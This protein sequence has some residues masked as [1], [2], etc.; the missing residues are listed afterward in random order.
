MLLH[1]EDYE[2]NSEK[3]KPSPMKYVE[4]YVKLCKPTQD[5]QQL[6]G[7]IKECIETYAEFFPQDKGTK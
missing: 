2:L 7:P 5:L 6:V 4:D 1:S 3:L